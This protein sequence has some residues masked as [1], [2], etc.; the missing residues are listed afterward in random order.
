MRQKLWKEI[1]EIYAKVHYLEQKI[2]ALEAKNA[3]TIVEA[4]NAAAIV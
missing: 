4:K 1:N 3:L 2:K